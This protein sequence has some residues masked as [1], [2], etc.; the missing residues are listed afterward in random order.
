[1]KK[2]TEKP[3]YIV[4][5]NQYALFL[6]LSCDATFLFIAVIWLRHLL[7]NKVKFGG[8]NI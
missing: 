7:K 4:D 6:F 3:R 1:V 2:V 5:I 8:I